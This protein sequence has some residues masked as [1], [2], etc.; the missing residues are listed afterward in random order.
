MLLWIHLPPQLFLKKHGNLNGGIKKYLSFRVFANL[1]GL[2]E[3][4]EKSIIKAKRE[5]WKSICTDIEGN[6]L[7]EVRSKI[8]A[9]FPSYGERLDILINTYFPGCTEEYHNPTRIPFRRT[10]TAVAEYALGI[11]L[12]IDFYSV[13]LQVV[14]SALRET[15]IYKQAEQ[16]S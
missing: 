11:F 4:F 14:T 1:Q 16:I 2:L 6:R 3:K 13:L 8:S 12:D 7:R 15:A 10:H 5:S 9:I